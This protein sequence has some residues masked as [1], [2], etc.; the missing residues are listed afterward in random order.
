MTM[1]RISR[2]LFLTSL[3]LLGGGYAI[4]SYP[5]L[6][7]KNITIAGTDR[8]A[9]GDL[10]VFTGQNVLDVDLKRVVNAV[11]ARNF[12]ERAT[13][14]FDQRGNLA[15]AVIEKKP[16]SYLFDTRLYA[17]T[18]NGELTP[19]NLADTILSLPI[20]QGVEADSV[21]LFEIIDNSGL[22]EAL[23]AIKVVREN[24][25]KMANSLSEVRVG[26]TG[27]GMIFEPGSIVVSLGWGDYEKKIKSVENILSSNKNPGLDLDMRFPEL[28]IM[29]S[30]TSNREAS[31]G[32]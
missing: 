15:V 27:L 30:R 29:K 6:T 32:I 25:P 24:C 22:R 12:V 11:I 3:L 14:N 18:E 2:L 13:A 31:N 20:I 28:A 1:R 7:V 4:K 10:P 23:K 5:V 9:V 21:K 17:V 8:I 19:S 26:Q 16:V